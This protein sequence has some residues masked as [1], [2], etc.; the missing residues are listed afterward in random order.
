M[1]CRSFRLIITAVFLLVACSPDSAKE[2]PPTAISIPLATVASVPAT[3]TPTVVPATQTPASQSILATEWPSQLEIIQSGNWARLQLLKT[4]PAEMPLKNS[5]VAI[6]PDGKTM[7]VGNSSG[8]R[9]FFFGLP[10]GQLLQ[11]VPIN[12]SDVGEYFNIV[13]MEYLPDGTIMA[14]SNGPY[15]IYHIDS[16]GNVLFA[17]DGV[18]FAISADKR[19]MA[20]DEEGITLVEIM[21]HTPLFSLE[22]GG[23]MYFSF[24][25]DG[26]KIAA[27]N[28]G[29][30]YLYTD[31]WDI[32][33][34]TPL[35]TLDETSNPRFSP[36]G[37]FLAVTKYDHEN[38]TTPVKIFSPDGATEITTLNVDEPNG[39][40][41]RAPLW[42]LDGSVIAAQIANGPPVAWD[43]TSWQPL[44]MPALQGELYSFSPDGRIL[45]TRTTD[46]GILLW[47]IVP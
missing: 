30:D 36:D 23:A 14:N 37:K 32:Q 27:E 3:Q 35:T 7:A 18:S 2:N 6:S 11:V 9:I 22:D 45:I 16:A 26:S 42:S 24:S 39:L 33:N 44:E 20:Y 17:W 5:A 10:S 41:N 34:K 46:G 12:L 4:F 40:N 1:Y 31:I 47:G 15:M 19:M 43:A 28:I 21:N 38:N 29:V 8:A 13:G 25:P